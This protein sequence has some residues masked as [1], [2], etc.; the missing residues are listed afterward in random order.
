MIIESIKEGF[1]LVHRNLALVFLRIAVNIINLT[2][3]FIFLGIPVIAAVALLGF[4]LAQ[5]KDLVPLLA[6]DP[7][8]VFSRYLGLMLTTVTAFIF[9]LFFASFFLL[10]ALSGI[11]GV[12]KKAAVDTQYKFTL[13]SFFREAGRNFSRLFWLISL[14][15]LFFIMILVGLVFLGGIIAAVQQLFAGGGGLV[16]VFF[17]SFFAL[18]M[19]IFGAIIFIAY[20]IF[21]V[22]AIIASV[23]DEGGSMDSVKRSFRFLVQKPGAFLFYLILIIGLVAANIVFYGVQASFHM[24]PVL[25]SFMSIFAFLISA[26]FQSYI[27]IGVWGAVMVY[28][29]KRTGHPVYS[30]S[31]EI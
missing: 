30:A 19:V 23:V 13:A 11:V 7:L 26:F 10:Y 5:A 21:V 27:A 1:R 6:R 3:V 22:Y 25:G 17:N 8:D 12:L 24:I 28:Y 20:F 16:E 18:S 2:G 9:Y 4:D 29:M 14:V 15:L 31:Y